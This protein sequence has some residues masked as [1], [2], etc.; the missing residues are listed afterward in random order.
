MSWGSPVR[1]ALRWLTPRSRSTARSCCTW[2]V[3]PSAQEETGMIQG[4]AGL[5]IV[6]VGLFSAWRQWRKNAESAAAC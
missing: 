2:G 1:C 4:L 6:A 3:V 5:A